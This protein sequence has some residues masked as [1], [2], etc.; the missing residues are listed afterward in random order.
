MAKNIC[1][2]MMLETL[3][4][5]M[6]QDVKQY[7]SLV[8][9]GQLYEYLMHEFT[10]EGLNLTRNETKNKMLNSFCKTG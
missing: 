4:V 5:S 9:S 2:R 7:I 6:K 8:V 10:K 3:K 1:L